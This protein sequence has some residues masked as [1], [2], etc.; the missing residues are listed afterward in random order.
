VINKE[1]LDW[2]SY[3]RKSF[4]DT[5]TIIVVVLT[6]SGKLL[7]SNESFKNMFPHFSIQKLL[8]PTFEKIRSLNFIEDRLLFNDIVTIGSYSSN[9]NLSFKAYIYKNDDQF[10]IVGQQAA[11]KLAE[12]NRKLNE[13]VRENNDLQRQLL[14][15]TK[16]LE[17][18]LNELDKVNVELKK[19]I[20]TKDK[21]FSI[22]AHDLRSPFNGI[23]GFS[24]ILK[25]N[26]PDLDQEEI[27]SFVDHIYNASHSYYSLILNL[28][29]WASLQ[30]KKYSFLPRKNNI[31]QL[32]S[33]VL[34][35]LNGNLIK[36][37]ITMEV[38]IPDE[39]DFFV[40]R[41]MFSA[42]M[43]NLVSNAIKFTQ[44]K[45]IIT[46]NGKIKQ[47]H[48]MVTI[49]DSGIGIPNEKIQKILN[50]EIIESTNGTDNEKGTGLGLSL[51]KE[52]I[53]I[54]GGTL[55]IKSKMYEGTSF[56]ISIPDVNKN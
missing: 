30:Q 37:E 4:F 39:T 20:Q 2:E 1:L 43:R 17:N 50:N 21:V 41:N 23:L 51:S 42:I 33:E 7:Y 54:H 16:I 53:E 29:D 26:L 12:Q 35:V 19:Q 55:S 36:K 49:Q 32:I 22:V 52:F 11:D 9:S 10:L 6:E 25:E 31:K 47:N 44:Q 45:G 18:T 13:I 3:I 15:K 48:L 5:D 24:E 46:I 14:K 56:T 8:N 27:K 40:D 28:L 38:S 34:L